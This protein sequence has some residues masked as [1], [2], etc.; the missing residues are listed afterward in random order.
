M[1]YKNPNEIG[2]PISAWFTGGLMG[3]LMPLL[4]VLIIVDLVLRGVSLWRSAR[5]E[6]K[7]WFIALLILNT[8]GI[9]PIIYL[10]F[11]QKKSKKH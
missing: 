3:G 10:L 7:G 11:F 1:W 4:V 8:V 2:G 6:Q 5:S 9:L